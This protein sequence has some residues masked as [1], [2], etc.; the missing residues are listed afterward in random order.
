M[1]TISQ[2]RDVYS[3]VPEIFKRPRPTE[4][5]GDDNM[6]PIEAWTVSKGIWD[7]AV[8]LTVDE[9]GAEKALTCEPLDHPEGMLPP[10]PGF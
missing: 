4:A 10:M 8:L 7:G 6:A 9:F 1:P 2:L 3:T 5:P